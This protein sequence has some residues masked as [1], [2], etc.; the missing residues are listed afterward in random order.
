MN[1]WVTLAGFAVITLVAATPVFAQGRFGNEAK[2]R[3]ADRAEREAIRRAEHPEQY[4]AVAANPAVT[5]EPPAI[6]E[7]AP[8]AAPIVQPA[9][10]PAAA[11]AQ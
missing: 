11:P 2:E 7:P 10:E 4:Q 1:R 3:A 9:P 6:P 5:R 8:E